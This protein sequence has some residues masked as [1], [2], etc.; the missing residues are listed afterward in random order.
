[1][2]AYL[3]EKHIELSEL[4]LA[5]TSNAPD[6]VATSNDVLIDVYTAA[7]NFFDLLQVAGK[8]QG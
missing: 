4:P 8:Y 6:P 2:K 5:F 7:F 3:I 1:M